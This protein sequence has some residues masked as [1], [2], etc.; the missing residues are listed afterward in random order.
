MEVLADFRLVNEIQVVRCGEEALDYLY[1]RGSFTARVLDN[2]VL[3]LLDLKMPKVDGL[4]V[5]W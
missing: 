1:R 2:P 4:E 3:I 5:L